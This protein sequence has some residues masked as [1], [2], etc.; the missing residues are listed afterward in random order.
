MKIYLFG[1][2]GMIGRYVKMVL[3]LQYNVIYIDRND[4][5][6]LIDN[7][8]K[9]KDILKN[10]KN[11]DVIINCIGIIPQKYKL[12]NY[13]TFIKVNS[14][15]PHKLQ[16]IAEKTDSKLIH[17]TTD[18]VYNGYRGLYKEDD[19][20]DEDNL[21]GISKSLGEP[22]NSCTIRTSIIGEETKN[23]TSLLEW[24]IS[25][26]DKKINGYV[27]HLW[28]GVTCL[29]L[30]NVIK[31][32]IENKFFWKGVRHIHSPNIVSKYDLCH[33]VN[34]IYNLNIEIVKYETSIIN[35]SL[36]TSYNNLLNY[37]ILDIKEQLKLQYIFNS[38][39]HILGKN[40]FIGNFLYNNIQ[41]MNKKIYSH[42]E[43]NFLSTNLNNNDIIINCCGVNRGSDEQLYNSNY[44]FVKELIN[45][46][47]LNNN[48]RFVNIS[49]LMASDLNN[50]SIFSKSKIM[51][52]NHIV[53]NINNNNNYT[54]LR[55]CNIL[56][57]GI[58]PYNNNFI[59]TL[60][61]EKQNNIINSTEYNVYNN[62][63]Y[64]LSME[65]VLDV[66]IDSI[67][68]PKNQILNV[69]SNKIF[70]MHDIIKILYCN[71]ETIEKYNIKLLNTVTQAKYNK[72]INN[73][74]KE[75]DIEKLIYSIK[76]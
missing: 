21:Y 34:D 66:V 41:C 8:F 59:Y 51:G 46:I 38:T 60:I 58:K 42:T 55:L 48:I 32:M 24:I 43:I 73:I 22:E 3:K 68:N 31:N 40:S 30:A 10:I 36:N 71:D 44:L 6:V 61:Y 75:C 29:T 16:E 62:N 54:V 70:K 5:D 4:Y 28:N 45:I 39:I 18:C 20:H 2:S 1:S 15:F 53:N 74:V 12:D 52:D 76:I 13:R 14:L 72:D 33:Y 57:N 23:K 49:S 47:N 64:I 65:K 67:I 27:N 50:N 63:I 69:I 37:N 7:D 26:K 56:D 35:K 9:L 17:I 19:K 25:N 11:N